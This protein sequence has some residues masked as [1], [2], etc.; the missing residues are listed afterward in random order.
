MNNTSHPIKNQQLAPYIRNYFTLDFSSLPQ[1]SIELKVPPMGFPVLQFHFGEN[2]N[3]YR[4]K[5]FTNQSLF[6]GQCT[7]HV[8]LY[9]SRGMKLLGVNFKPY[10]L[11][12]LFGISPHG[13]TNSGVESSSFMGKENIKR[14]SQTLKK[15]GIEKGISEIE[16]LLLANQNKCVK[17]Q[18]YFD[19]LVDK[20]E[21]ENGLINYTGLL[22]KNVSV[23]TFQ[24][25]FR[26][27]IGISPKMFCQ[28]LRHKYIMELLYKNAEM[29]WSDMQLNGFYYDFAHFTKD[30]TQF[31]GLTPRKY[32]P[33]KNSFAAT[34]L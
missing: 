21:V 7:R 4:H 28:V 31:S 15:D 13:L 11:Y 9:P 1:E 27:V 26:E 19:E 24:R 20:M 8:I 25:Y 23:R 22:D 14:I 10:G 12:N 34:L 17:L 5:H 32:L 30:F 6:I 3:F 18:P 16:T 29:K 33:L 2:V